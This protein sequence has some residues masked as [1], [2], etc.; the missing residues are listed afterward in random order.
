MAR[1]TKKYTKEETEQMKERF[2]DAFKTSNGLLLHTCQNVNVCKDQVYKWLDNDP[3]FKEAY[4]DIKKSSIEFVEGQLMTLIR[5]GN[6]AAI[7]FFLK[8]RAHWKESSKIEID[9]PNSID[10]QA[11]LADIKEQLAK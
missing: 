6:A 8:C 1:R 3:E 9:N 10:V 11:A 7:M 4:E 2:L 5:Q